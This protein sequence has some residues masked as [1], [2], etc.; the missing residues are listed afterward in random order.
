[1]PQL[2]LRCPHL[3]PRTCERLSYMTKGIRVLDGIKLLS[4][5][6]KREIILN[7]LGVPNVILKSGRG[8]KQRER[9]MW[10]NKTGQRDAMLLA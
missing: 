8:R 4:A 9:E 6:L 10:L 1:M 7:C 3:T 2:P 5:D